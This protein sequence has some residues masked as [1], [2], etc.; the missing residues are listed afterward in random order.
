[1]MLRLA[2]SCVAGWAAYRPAAA[3]LEFDWRQAAPQRPPS[4]TRRIEAVDGPYRA[5][6]SVASPALGPTKGRPRLGRRCRLGAKNSKHSVGVDPTFAEYVACE[7]S[8]VCLSSGRDAA[9]EYHGH[10][11]HVRSRLTMRAFVTMPLVSTAL[12]SGA[13]TRGSTIFSCCA[14]LATV[15]V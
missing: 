15:T 2:I 11:P 14:R 5:A 8:R 9:V 10:P 12:A 3:R 7:A 4:T 6:S 13:P 1:M